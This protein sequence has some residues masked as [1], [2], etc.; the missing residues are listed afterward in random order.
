MSSI[1]KTLIGAGLALLASAAVVTMPGTA[2]A[3]ERKPSGNIHAI[4]DGESDCA[5]EGN[6]TRWPDNCRNKVDEVFNDGVP[7]GRD[8]VNLYWGSNWNG[9]YACIG[10]GTRWNLR[11]STGAKYVFNWIRNGDTD[12]RGEKV[13]D[14]VASHKWVTSCGNNT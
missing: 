11:G 7:G 4:V 6:S 3:D 2:H 9:A 5:W 14:N 12:G 8:H 10:Y 1:R 13:H